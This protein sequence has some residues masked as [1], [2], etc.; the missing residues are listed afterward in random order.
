MSRKRM[1]T[2][3]GRAKCG[4]WKVTVGD[5]QPSH[6]PAPDLSFFIPQSVDPAKVCSIANILQPHSPWWD[7]QDSCLWSASFVVCLAEEIQSLSYTAP[8]SSVLVQWKWTWL[9]TTRLQIQ[10]LALLSGISGLRIRCCRELWCRLATTVPIRPLAWQP[11][12][13]MG[14]ALKRQKTKKKIMQLN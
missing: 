8:R 6:F 14:A 12:Y 1:A 10:S 11:P 7:L 13:A 4:Q 3:L 9:G 2:N 5:L